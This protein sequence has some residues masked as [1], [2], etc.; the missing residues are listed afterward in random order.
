MATIGDKKVSLALQDG[1]SI[2]LNKPKVLPASITKIA[3]IKEPGWY[4][5]GT[6]KG[7]GQ[8]PVSLED[9]SAPSTLSEDDGDAAGKSITNAD[10]FDDSE[11][12]YVITDGPFDS[13]TAKKVFTLFVYPLANQGKDVGFLNGYG[14]IL[15]YAFGYVFSGSQTINSSSEINWYKLVTT[16]DIYNAGFIDEINDYYKFTSG[17]HTTA[18]STKGAVNLYKDLDDA[19]LDVTLVPNTVS[20]NQYYIKNYYCYADVGNTVKDKPAGVDGFAMYVD[21]AKKEDSTN[22]SNNIYHARQMLIALNGDNA[23]KTYFRT[24][25]GGSTVSWTDWKEYGTEIIDNLTSTD[26]TKAL[27]ANQ[28]KVLN[29]KITSL[30]KDDVGLDLVDN[31]PDEEKDVNN[32]D[33][34]Q[35]L[36]TKN[37]DGSITGLSVGNES[38]PVYFD[39][40]GT[41]QEATNVMPKPIYS[42]TDLTPGTSNLADGQIY[43]V[44]YN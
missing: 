13:N 23:W 22:S 3:D 34:A 14:Y 9:E 31:T 36:A 41:P 1:S 6:V 16:D 42:S 24:R 18:F 8:N 30:T 33:T 17:S 11:I 44:Y 37:S 7:S 39:Q 25:S 2:N 4:I 29:D 19:K 15:Y 21:S 26:T 10:L 5:G 12:N 35:H 43:I 27:S 38:T 40:K 32:A 28:G 20:L